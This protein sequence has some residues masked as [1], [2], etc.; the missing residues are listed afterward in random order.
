[1]QYHVICSSVET[2]TTIAQRI[3]AGDL[4]DCYASEALAV[5]AWRAQPMPCWT[6]YHVWRVQITACAVMAK[7]LELDAYQIGEKP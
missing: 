3:H 1:M 6:R 4:S 7:R 2:A 5:E